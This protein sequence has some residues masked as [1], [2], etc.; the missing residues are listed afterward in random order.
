MF[1]LFTALFE[2]RSRGEEETS[3]EAPAEEQAM[4]GIAMALAE[5]RH[6]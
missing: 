1:I 3:N 2:A 6:Q 5:R 4:V